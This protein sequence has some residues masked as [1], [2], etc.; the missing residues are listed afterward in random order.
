MRE[1]LFFVAA[2]LPSHSEP[3]TDLLVS[4]S[5]ESLLFSDTSCVGLWK[6]LAAGGEKPLLASSCNGCKTNIFPG[7]S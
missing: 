1:F 5:P 2:T 4:L 7:P 3:A 6:G